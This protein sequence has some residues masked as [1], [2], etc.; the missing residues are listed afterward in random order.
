MVNCG[1]DKDDDFHKCKGCKAR[2]KEYLNVMKII[3]MKVGVEL[4]TINYF[5]KANNLSKHQN[6]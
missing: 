2:K 4:A 1:S 3:V 5:K 6:N